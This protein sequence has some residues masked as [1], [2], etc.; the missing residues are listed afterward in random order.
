[1]KSAPS[2]CII[3]LLGRWKQEERRWYQKG[4]RGWGVVQVVGEWCQCQAERIGNYQVKHPSGITSASL[5]VRSDHEPWFYGKNNYFTRPCENEIFKR[6]KLKLPFST[7]YPFHEHHVSLQRW[8]IEKINLLKPMPKYCTQTWIALRILCFK[9]M[10]EL[11]QSERISQTIW[12][13]WLNNF[14][15]HICTSKTKVGFTG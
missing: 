11:W 4:W 9:L 13:P 8:Q 12:T 14:N 7:N 2:F 10:Q 3:A 6:K 15:A 5:P 1:M